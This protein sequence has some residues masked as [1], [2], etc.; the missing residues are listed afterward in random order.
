VARPRARPP[1]RQ[2]GDVDV[3]ARVKCRYAMPTSRR[4]PREPYPSPRPQL[5]ASGLRVV[6]FGCQSGT[7][8]AIRVLPCQQ[9]CVPCHHLRSSSGCACGVPGVWRALFLAG[10]LSP[11]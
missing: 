10:Y 4:S 1:R 11:C 7:T 5:L 3:D 2:W 9:P 8:C 6:F